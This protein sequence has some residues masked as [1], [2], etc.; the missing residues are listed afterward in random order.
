MVEVRAARYSG[1]A[2]TI[3]VYLGD[4]DGFVCVRGERG[5]RCRNGEEIRGRDDDTQRRDGNN[6]DERARRR[7]VGETAYKGVDT[8]L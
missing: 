4:A 8:K 5:E 3:V 1:V 2:R 6:R 7:S